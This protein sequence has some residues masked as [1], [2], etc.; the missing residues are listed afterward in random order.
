MVARKIQISKFGR[1]RGRI[2]NFGVSFK[3]VDRRIQN[4][5]FDRCR[6]RIWDFDFW[7][8]LKMIARKIQ[9]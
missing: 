3:M 4:L 7:Y 9:K 8:K 5:I 6:G 1:C 2:L